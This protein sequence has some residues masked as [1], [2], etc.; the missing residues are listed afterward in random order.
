LCPEKKGKVRKELIADGLV[1]IKGEE[2][3]GKCSRINI[4]SFFFK[5]HETA[6]CTMNKSEV[7]RPKERK[8]KEKDQ[9]QKKSMTY[10]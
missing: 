5:K 1:F 6:L 10:V 3:G 8:R 2:K 9:N 7:R 4:H